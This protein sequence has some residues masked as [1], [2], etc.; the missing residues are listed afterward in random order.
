MAN[1]ATRAF[2][3]YGGDPKY[4]PHQILQQPNQQQ[5]QY[6]LPPGI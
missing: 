4:V 5:L 3:L 2:M 1:W 6:T